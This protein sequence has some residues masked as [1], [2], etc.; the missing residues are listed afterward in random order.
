M[1]G[2]AEDNCSLQ[3]PWP[4]FRELTGPGGVKGA[5]RKAASGL[6]SLHFYAWRALNVWDVGA[7]P[8]LELVTLS[9][10]SSLCCLC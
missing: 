4:R 10:V 8:G 7:Q 6:G 2:L 1:L 9:G 3:T 5:S